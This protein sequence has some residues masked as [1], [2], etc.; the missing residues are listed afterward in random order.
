MMLALVGV[1]VGLA[2]SAAASED[3]SESQTRV[4]LQG[5]NQGPVPDDFVIP[6]ATCERPTQ[7]S[8]MVSLRSADNEHVCGGALFAPNWVVTAARCIDPRVSSSAIVTPDV[9]IAGRNQ[10][11]PIETIKSIEPFFHPDWID[12][13]KVDLALLKLERDS[14]LPFPIDLAPEDFEFPDPEDTT[15]TF[16]AFGREDEQSGFSVQL[17]AGDW[18]MIPNDVC[19]EDFAQPE[20]NVTDTMLCARG[21]ATPGLCPGDAGGPLFYRPPDNPNPRLPLRFLVGIG[22]F[23]DVDCGDAEGASFFT[24][25][26]KTFKWINETVAANQ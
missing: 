6:P 19:Q 25:M 8:F 24:S 9:D 11:E 26:P 20:T 2:G 16:V 15:Y 7:F 3:L 22:S 10:N 14:C 21:A 12:G 5:G 1:L 18:R 13:N 17:Q 4:L 23:T